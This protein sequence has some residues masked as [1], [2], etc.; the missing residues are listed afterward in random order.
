MYVLLVLYRKIYFAR[1]EK[2]DSA[3]ADL[4]RCIYIADGVLAGQRVKRCIC[5]IVA[6]G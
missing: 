4:T 6:L 5:S 3:G 1:L 2:V